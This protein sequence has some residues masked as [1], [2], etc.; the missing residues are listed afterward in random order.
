MKKSIIY[1]MISIAL[2][3]IA[4]FALVCGITATGHGFLDL[5]NIVRGV[6]YCIAAILA[7]LAWIFFKKSKVI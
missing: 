5:S 7:I 2:F 1:K 3:I 6:C 4:I